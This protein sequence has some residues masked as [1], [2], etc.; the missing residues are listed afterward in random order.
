MGYIVNLHRFIVFIY[1]TARHTEKGI[2]DTRPFTT[3]SHKIKNVGIK[4]TKDEKD[5]YNGNFKPTFK[6]SFKI[7]NEERK[8]LEN[9]ELSRAHGL[10]E[11]IV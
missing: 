10:V 1:A 9:R 8:T 6:P 3:T 7:L 5:L 4:L 2:T 11:L